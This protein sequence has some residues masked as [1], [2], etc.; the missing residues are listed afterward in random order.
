[1]PRRAWVGVSPLLIWSTIGSTSSIGIAKPRPIEPASP[2]E[3]LAVRIEELMPTTLPFR[4]TSAP[5]LLPGL[6]AASVWMAGYVVL[7]PSLS[8]PTST[9]RLSALTM[10]LV[11]VD[12]RPNG[13]PIAT[14]PS[15]TL[16]SLDLPMV[17][18]VRPETPSALM[19]AVSVSGSVPTTFALADVPS[20][21]RRSSSRRRRRSPRRGCW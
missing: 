11:T 16:R 2:S 7:L 5:P 15:P 17:A 4:S 19:T 14:T 3:E 6:I 10:P 8:E 1:M 12:S 20:L 9:G 18:G 13:E 21:K